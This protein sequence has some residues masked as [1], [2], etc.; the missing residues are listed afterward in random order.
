MTPFVISPY[1]VDPVR[2]KLTQ[3]SETETPLLT[4]PETKIG[5]PYRVIRS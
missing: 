4:R 2:A 3:L 1:N 5:F